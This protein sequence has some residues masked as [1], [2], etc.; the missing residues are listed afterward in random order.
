MNIFAKQFIA[1]FYLVIIMSLISFTTIALCKWLVL[2]EII[3]VSGKIKNISILSLYLGLF[4]GAGLWIMY[5]FNF[6]K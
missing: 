4:G 5:R 3:F 2:D 1:Y 6:Y